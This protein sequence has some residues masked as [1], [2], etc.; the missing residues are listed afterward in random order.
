MA[1][2]HIDAIDRQHISHIRRSMLPLAWTARIIGKHPSTLTRELRRNADPQGGYQTFHANAQARKRRRQPRGSKLDN[3]EKLRQYVLE[4]LTGPERFSPEILAARIKRDH[5]DDPSMRIS[6]QAI[7]D[8]IERDKR[9]AEASGYGGK[10][11][12][13]LRRR[14]KSY[15]KNRTKAGRSR[16]PNRV[17]IEHRPPEVEKRQEV[18]HFEG[19][20]I[21]GNKTNACLATFVE[22][23]TRI[24]R[25]RRCP[26][27]RAKVVTLA[28]VAALQS[29]PSVILKTITFDN[30]SEF[31]HHAKLTEQTG[32]RVFFA[33]PYSSWERGTNEN[34]NGLIRAYF[35]KRTNFSRVT[36]AEIAYVEDLLNN[37]PRKC[38][39][40]RTPNEALADELA[41]AI[42]V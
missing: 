14:G 24:T 12:K 3:N 26:N 39:N 33:N 6:H 19:D 28:A 22:R 38:L 2:T 20:T 18:G 25:I 29:L 31:S 1:H 4:R 34:T 36:D 17:G 35:P 41:V 16:I 8:F 10:L 9:L 37:R 42:G 23:K 15:R 30:G 11:F 27:R 7:Y 5:P 21:Y 40:W 13:H 32:I